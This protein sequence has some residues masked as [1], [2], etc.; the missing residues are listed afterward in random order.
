MKLAGLIQK[1]PYLLVYIFSGVASSQKWRGQKNFISW[2]Q[3]KSQ[4]A[5]MVPPPLYIQKQI[6]NGF[7]Q[8]SR[9]VWTLVGAG[10]PYPPIPSR[11]DATV[12]FTFGHFNIWW[13][14]HPG[15]NLRNMI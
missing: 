13:V 2:E 15:L 4:Y 1:V 12:Y 5:C 9:G 6:I 11:G 7:V 3:Y 14:L 8:I 10:G